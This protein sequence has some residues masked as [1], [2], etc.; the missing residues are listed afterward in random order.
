MR[1]RLRTLLILLAIMPPI[2]GISYVRWQ[3]YR[4]HQR[5][6]EIIKSID[7]GNNMGLAWQAFLTS[8]AAA[9]PPP[10]ADNSNQDNFQKEPPDEN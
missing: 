3:R 7:Y 2:L 6:L 4:E 5:L 1:Y 9:P 8:Q 10:P